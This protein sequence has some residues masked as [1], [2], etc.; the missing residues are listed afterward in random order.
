MSLSLFCFSTSS[1]H[2]CR[3]RLQHPRAHVPGKLWPRMYKVKLRDHDDH[4][5]EDGPEL[6]SEGSERRQ[7]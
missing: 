2:R 3:R 5:E 1:R 7:P 4:D 6:S